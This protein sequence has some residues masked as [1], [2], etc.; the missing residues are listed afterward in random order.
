MVSNEIDDNG[1]VLSVAY[2]TY[3]EKPKFT[4]MYYTY[5]QKGRISSS[6]NTTNQKQEFFYLENGLLSNILNYNPKGELEAEYI[7]EYTYRE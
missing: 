7:F 6:Y 2:T 1:L 5:D 4:Q 3:G